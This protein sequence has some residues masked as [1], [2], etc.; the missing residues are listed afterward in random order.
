MKI[1]SYNVNG[2]RSV[3]NKGLIEW[4]LSE[5][6][7]IINFQEIKLYETHLIEP[8]FAELGFQCYWHPA[9][10]RGYSGVATLTKLTPLHVQV[11]MQ[12]ELYDFEGR[13]LVNYFD[14]FVLVN[15]YF[16]SGSSGDERQ[17]FKYQF[18]N[19]Y[20]V[21]IEELKKQKK[22]IIICGDVNICHQAIDIHNPEKNK[23]TSGF[24]SE[25]RQWITNLLN[26]GF[27]DA[28]RLFDNSPHNYTWWTYR[29]GAK[30]KNLG[31]RIDYFFIENSFIN[32]IKN[33]QI[34][35]N[36]AFSDHCPITI[37]ID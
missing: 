1:I 25:E 22:P 28:F 8:I 31:W 18:L 17:S 13:V 19:D 12:N 33:S 26:S 36:I 4:I 2:I 32:R 16:P 27:S 20:F 5:N 34:L 37:E 23:N 3:L 29:A 10:K 35:N 9:Q 21:F 14:E 30:A 15:T 24:L 6:P 11:G 7:T